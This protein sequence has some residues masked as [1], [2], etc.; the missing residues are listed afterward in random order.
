MFGRGNRN[1][2]KLTRIGYIENDV[3]LNLPRI[4]SLESWVNDT[5]KQMGLLDRRLDK[6]IQSRRL[7][8][9]LFEPSAPA[10]ATSDLADGAPLFTEAGPP[11][12]P[13]P[14]P[15]L[16]LPGMA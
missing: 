16:A 4:A 1:D 6:V 14:L 13:A 12:Q 5:V 11:A 9:D 3:G 15:T 2:E 8:E 10:M 7:E